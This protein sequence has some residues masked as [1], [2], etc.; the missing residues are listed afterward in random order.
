MHPRVTSGKPNPPKSSYTSTCHD[1]S[2][3][4]AQE[5]LTCHKRKKWTMERV[6]LPQSAM[7]VKK[8]RPGRRCSRPSHSDTSGPRSTRARLRE[9]ADRFANHA[10]PLSSPR[11]GELPWTSAA[12][13]AWSTS[14]GHSSIPLGLSGASQQACASLQ[15]R[16][17]Q[18]RAISSVS[19]LVSLQ[20]VHM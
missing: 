1:E 13:S 3:V 10:G 2:A 15:L 17:P 18:L 20:T 5:G 4:V 8:A 7:P 16:A 19:L 11:C 12:A 9:H 6:E 14:S